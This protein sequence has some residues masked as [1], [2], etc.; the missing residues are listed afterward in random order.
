MSW[1]PVLPK[2][3]TVTNERQN[4]ASALNWDQLGLGLLSDGSEAPTAGERRTLAARREGDDPRDSL[5]LSKQKRHK[6]E[7]GRGR[8]K[9]RSKGGD[10]PHFLIQG[11]LFCS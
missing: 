10:G 1:V 6:E 5:S 7:N 8:S 4:Q 2:T 9:W 3:A 11:V